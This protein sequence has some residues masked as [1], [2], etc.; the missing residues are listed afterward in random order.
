[1]DSVKN[2]LISRIEKAIPSMS[3]GQKSIASYILANYEHAAYMTAARI[4]EDAGVSES[5]VVRFAMELGYDGYPHF[6]KMLQE[7]LK[8]RL[9]SVQRMRA[10]IK[11]TDNDDILGAVLQSKGFEVVTAEERPDLRFVVHD[12]DLGQ[13]IIPT[14]G[15]GRWPRGGSRPPRG[16]PRRAGAGP[17]PRTRAPCP[18]RG[19]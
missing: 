11:L 10:S 17:A 4:G 12:Q 7:E 14:S 8:V 15:A 19:S 1:M 9:P 6:Q 18:G 5:T 2:N 16:R 3:K 13:P